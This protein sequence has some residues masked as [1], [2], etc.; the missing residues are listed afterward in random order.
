MEPLSSA[1]G[2]LEPTY[3]VS[4]LGAAIRELLRE[5]LPEVWL[6]G[7][8]QRL[9]V[10]PS[11]HRYFELVEKGPGDAIVGKLEAV[12]W[13]GEFPRIAAELARQAALD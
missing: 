7:E 9:V 11:G 8:L 6:V 13:R 1:G 4:Q 5:A 2:L 12:L 3:T 10:R